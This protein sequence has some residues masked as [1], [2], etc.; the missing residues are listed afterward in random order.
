MCWASAWPTPT[1]VAHRKDFPTIT[2][3]SRII[4]PVIE[5]HG[6]DRG[7]GGPKDGNILVAIS[8]I[9]W[10]L[11]VLR[12]RPQANAYEQ[13]SET[14]LL[15]SR[16]RRDNQWQRN[17]QTARAASAESP[18]AAGR[19][20]TP[21]DRPRHRPCHPEKRVRQDTGRVQGEA[22]PGHPGQSGAS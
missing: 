21:W 19:A 18:M 15:A 13:P 12:K 22:G 16:K 6:V 10:Y 5:V 17:E 2:L 1:R 8:G 9:L 4:V 7:A 14:R 11:F 20:D 3:G